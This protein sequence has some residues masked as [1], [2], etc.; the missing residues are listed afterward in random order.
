MGVR[1]DRRRVPGRRGLGLCVAGI[2]G[3]GLWGAGVPAVAAFGA[4]AWGG[5]AF[6]S[7]T[8][9]SVELGF[10]T[11]GST[12]N[13]SAGTVELRVLLSA[14]SGVD[15]ELGVALSGTAGED[16]RS[17]ESALPL[18]IPAGETEALVRL[19]LRDDPTDEPVET[20]ELEL[21]AP[22][23]VAVGSTLLSARHV[24]S[25]EDDD[26]PPRVG[27][28]GA[29]SRAGENGTELSLEIELSAPS[30][31][32]VT[33]PFTL[34]GDAVL[35]EDFT[36][37][38][39]PLVIPAGSRSVVLT[40]TAVDDAFDEPDETV[41]VT[42]GAPTNASLGADPIQLVTLEDDEAPPVVDFVIGAQTAL[43]GA[44]S[45]R[46][47]VQLS[48][49]SAQDVTVTYG[50][51]GSATPG[52]DFVA[53][54]GLVTIPAGATRAGFDVRL[55]EDDLD[56]EDEHLQVSLGAP[57]HATLGATVEHVLTLTDDD[58]TPRVELALPAQ[59]VGEAAGSA[60]VAVYLTAGSS[61][62]IAVP[63]ALSGTASPGQDFSGLPASVVFPAGVLEAEIVLEIADDA[64]HEHDET[65]ELRLGTAEHVEPGG[66]S[67]HLLTLEDDDEPPSARF[68][69]AAG[70][71]GETAGTVLVRVE[72][73]APSGLEVTLP[74]QVGGNAEHGKDYLLLTPGPLVLP[75]GSRG[76][77]IG[78]SIED[79]AWHE[80]GET[81][82]L[83]LGEAQGATLGAVREQVLT[84]QSDDPP[85]AVAFT[86]ASQAAGE[87]TGTV[88]AL[89]EL[90]AISGAD[91]RV[92]LVADPSQGPGQASPGGDF[93][94]GAAEVVI[95]HGALSASVAI[96]LL[97]DALHEG[98]E[99][100]VI[101]LGDPIGA[102]PGSI[103]AHEVA[104]LD[105]DP[106]PTARFALG[107]LARSEAAGPVGV[108]VLLDAPSA[109]DAV[110]PYSL[111]GLA[112]LGEDYLVSASPLVIPA[113]ATKGTITFT[114]IDDPHDEPQAESV[115]LTL[116]APLENALLGTPA[117]LAIELEDDDMG[118]AGGGGLRASVGEILFATTRLGE[119]SA[120]RTVVVT[121]ESDDYI[122]FAG[123]D[124]EGP[125]GGSFD[126]EYV[127]DPP[128]FGLE[129]GASTSVWISFQ[130]KKPGERHAL[131]RVC[132]GN[133]LF[134]ISD[135]PVIDLLGIGLGPPGAEAL[136]NAGPTAYVDESDAFWAPSFCEV[137][138]SVFVTSEAEIAGTEDDPLYRTARVG[139]WFGYSIPVPNG[140]YDVRL[141]FAEIEGLAQ[142][143]FDVWLEGEVVL[144]DFCPPRPGSDTGDPVVTAVVVPIEGVQVTGGRFDLTVV[145]SLGEGLLSAFEL[146][147]VPVLATDVTAVEFGVVGL[148]EVAE[149][150]VTVT[151][152][153][154]RD[155]HVNA[156]TFRSSGPCQSSAD[157]FARVDG[158]D[159]AGGDEPVDHALDLVVPAGSASSFSL[160]FRPEHP[161]NVT[162]RLSLAT[163]DGAVDLAVRGATPNVF[164]GLLHPE[165]DCEPS[166][167]VDY[168]GDGLERVRLTAVGSHTHETDH[169]LA[170]YRWRLDRA[171]AGEEAVLERDLP[172]GAS[173]VELSVR[174]DAVP[175]AQSSA[176]AVVRVHSAERVP[177][178]L[179]G[180]HDAPPASALGIQD[181][182]LGPASFLARRPTL[183]VADRGGD[184][185]GARFERP[186][187]VRLQAA[188][189][190]Q[191]VPSFVELVPR[192]GGA[193][194]VRID[195]TLQEGIGGQELA[196][197]WHRLEARFLVETRSQLPL[198]VEAHID[199]RL[200][201]DFAAGLVHSEL[202][203]APVLTGVVTDSGTAILEGFGFYP[204]AGVV[205]R[206]GDQE[207]TGPELAHVSPERIE[208]AV[209]SSGP[210]RV[211]VVTPSGASGP[212]P[213]G[214]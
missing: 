85:P 91:V 189:E 135:G 108:E 149:Q 81:I 110:L 34:G 143:S 201:P 55:L 168:D 130:P 136:V 83:R 35:S 190:I 199:G 214:R 147:S 45:V 182:P 87:G 157:F 127:D 10:E 38:P 155:G 208:L 102:E 18:R 176:S 206:W 175:P 50:F 165:I 16:E 103:A 178:V 23:G 138:S 134:E 196:P 163:D 52:E 13:E 177:G 131:A 211:Q 97:A 193:R 118:R 159:Y 150:V 79:D 92:P 202:E 94:L 11:A 46:I 26:D 116:E 49:P 47:E 54:G 86:S 192:G 107:A 111:A 19:V 153:G 125:A 124:L 75:P 100:A 137:G 172:L 114:P 170:G 3:A 200:A 6:G 195:G 72:L 198:S 80:I 145:A 185:P 57:S 9:G 129:A 68:L 8:T 112:T 4:V 152:E 128:P 122:V 104:I 67:V 158:Q 141:H 191:G 174:D 78:L 156:L 17:L 115:I 183:R 93:S 139:P 29:S 154:L 184:A 53:D 169:R 15:L 95:P 212:I 186:V 98:P 71:V 164:A 197:G 37:P 113:G 48:T 73:S 70:S 140:E 76:T 44:P 187:L 209:P 51:S 36:A 166:L 213:V 63:L 30:G 82:V 21:T 33:V 203:L 205:V 66:L 88:T 99:L 65:V 123:L 41:V 39:S 121:N 25:I 62:E 204:A 133:G 180:I 160:F 96:D 161:Q 14:P 132:E 120:P 207:L 162:F 64:L 28:R 59:A 43:E 109:L 171:W 20:V 56:E 126:V 58:E 42:L 60:R 5:A 22:E 7:Q 74:F 179:L 181:V 210:A 117:S 1:L 40:L 89:L 84:I 105:D 173:D 119:S 69:A 61:F 90:S 106:A 144:T 24:L 188:F 2:W 151:N 142:R 27:F 101:R 32:P 31:F 167:V 194:S 148:G 12:V 146:R 77:E